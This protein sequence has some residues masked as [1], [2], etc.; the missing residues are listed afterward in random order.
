[1]VLLVGLVV[2]QE[3]GG[4]TCSKEISAKNKVGVCCDQKGGCVLTLVVQE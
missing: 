3:D 2:G 1:M 4:S